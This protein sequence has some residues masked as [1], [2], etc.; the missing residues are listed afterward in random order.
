M[1]FTDRFVYVHQPKTGGSFV[2]S[3]LYRLHLLDT[4]LVSL[5]R[6]WNLPRREHVYSGRYGRFVYGKNKHGT[7]SEIPESQR[8]KPILGTIRNPYDRY[9]SQYE[10]GWWKRR[11]WLKYYEAVPG[12]KERYPHFPDLSF[13]EH[14]ELE[15]AAFG[16]LQGKDFDRKDGLG[17]QTVQFVEFYFRNPGEVL[18][19]IDD[20]YI[21]ERQFEADLHD[22]HFLHTARLNRELYDFLLS[23]DYE[24]EDL[25][26]ILKMDRVLPNGKGRSKDQA[27][28]KYYTPGLKAL[29][30]RRNRLLFAL[31]PE[32]DQ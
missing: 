23:L 7:C 18:P 9:V 20:R 16:A 30:Q 12:F 19:R 5:K 6:L 31:F 24:P 14:L 26:F 27:W 28:Q 4:K 1:I 25:R 17:L 32:F 21:E 2:T 10:F 13:A 11:E 8:H 22:V 3:A 29:V 15:H